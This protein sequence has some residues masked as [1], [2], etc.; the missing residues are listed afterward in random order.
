MIHKVTKAQDEDVCSQSDI[1][2]MTSRDKY[3]SS[4]KIFYDL[5]RIY[6]YTL[7]KARDPSNVRGK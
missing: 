6:G 1:R 4:N 7:K 3:H 2:T 5:A